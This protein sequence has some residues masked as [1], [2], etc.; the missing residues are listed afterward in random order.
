MS[1]KTA[2]AVTAIACALS[3]NGDR[4]L[5]RSG[6]PDSLKAQ[7]AP[8]VSEVFDAMNS[9]LLTG[10]VG[11]AKASI[12]T[13]HIGTVLDGRFD[14]KYRDYQSLVASNTAVTGQVT[15]VTIDSISGTK[16]RA[17]VTVEERWRY[18]LATT[19][20]AT[21]NTIYTEETERHKLTVSYATDHWELLAYESV[22]GLGIHANQVDPTDEPYPGEENLQ[23]P[24]PGDAPSTGPR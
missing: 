7:V 16:A 23:P 24:P 8:I 17:D 14:E 9:V 18:S 22:N 10:N 5:A 20:V 3:A 6:G 2:L 12:S 15:T 4:A 19:D 21:G 1:Y 13:V 11:A